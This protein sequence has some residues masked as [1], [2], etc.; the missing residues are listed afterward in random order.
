MVMATEEPITPLQAHQKMKRPPPSA[1]T[2]VNGVKSSQSP[3]PSL[4]SKRPP[5][6][7][8]NALVGASATGAQTNGGGS[9]FIGRPRRE[10]QKPGD[11]HGRQGKNTVRLANGEGSSLDRRPIKRLPEPLGV[12][13]LSCSLVSY[14]R[15]TW[16]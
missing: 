9:R 12:L 8:K 7:T 6:A 14:T 2:A 4:S 5:G 10:S 1:S 13:P 16:P 15:R 11:M 3:S